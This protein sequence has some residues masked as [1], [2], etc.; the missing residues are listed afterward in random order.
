MKDNPGS[1]SISR[2]K[3]SV[4]G[5][6][7]VMNNEIS[8]FVKVLDGQLEIN[9][10]ESETSSPSNAYTPDPRMVPTKIVVIRIVRILDFISQ[11]LNI[12]FLNLFVVNPAKFFK[13]IA[14]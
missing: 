2:K 1:H 13:I 8:S 7:L 3:V 14:F 5:P 11:L 6:V 9:V 12:K 4:V 10:G